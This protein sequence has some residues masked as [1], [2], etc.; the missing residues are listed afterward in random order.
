[1]A[2]TARTADVQPLMLPRPRAGGGRLAR[3][4]A[5]RLV[6]TLVRWDSVAG[7]LRR[8]GL[9]CRVLDFPAGSWSEDVGTTR[10]NLL[11]SIPQ[12]IPA[13]SPVGSPR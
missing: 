13:P 11:I 3:R 4:L 5:R 7:E 6:R 1:M 2:Q 9:D 12:G 8:A 10:S